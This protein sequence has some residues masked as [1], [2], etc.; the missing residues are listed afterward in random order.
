MLALISLLK[1][2][3]CGVIVEE[4]PHPDVEFSL[5]NQKWS[6]NIF[7]D[8]ETVMFN[9]DDSILWLGVIFI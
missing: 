2:V 8:D 9:F 5:V 3:D 6:L 4:D 1:N 7:L